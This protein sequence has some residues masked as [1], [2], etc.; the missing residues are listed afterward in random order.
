MKYYIVNLVEIGVDKRPFKI[1]GLK[2]YRLKEA[3][4]KNLQ[5][6]ALNYI[7]EKDGKQQGDIAIQD[8]IIDE[9]KFDESLRDGLYIIKNE[10]NLHLYAKKKVKQEGYIYNSYETIINEIG[11][12]MISE[13][14]VDVPEQSY[15]CSCHLVLSSHKKLPMEQ[16]MP[17]VNEINDLLRNKNLD[18]N[19]VTPSM[20][21][22]EKTKYKK[23]NFVKKD[24]DSSN[25]SLSSDSLST[26]SLS[27]DSLSSDS[28]C[29]SLSSDLA[30]KDNFSEWNDFSEDALLKDTNTIFKKLEED[31]IE[32]GK[33][34]N[35]C[36]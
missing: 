11:I 6:I 20:L 9:I 23:N 19:H 2:S 1:S 36:K 8:K 34:N 15:K 5:E 28:D 21:G 3:A 4:E 31:I 26:D 22:Y 18:D 17:F 14:N 7:I 35:E 33:F 30:K 16:H 13:V 10:C 27:T 29:D 32:L 24:N 25:D 12:F